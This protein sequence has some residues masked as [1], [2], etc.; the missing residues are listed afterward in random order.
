MEKAKLGVLGVCVGLI[1][2]AGC[3]ASSPSSGNLLSEDECTTLFDKVEEIMASGLSDSDQGE[4]RAMREE[5]GTSDAKL[6]S[7][8]SGESWTREGF[9][10]AMEASTENQLK[11]CILG[12]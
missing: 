2:L 6:Q 5:R 4:Y 11:D 10:C 3:G 8:L 1:L 12:M 9:D 7:C